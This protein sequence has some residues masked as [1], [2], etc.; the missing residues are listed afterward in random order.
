MAPLINSSFVTVEMNNSKLCIDFSSCDNDFTDDSC[1]NSLLL[2]IEFNNT[3]D[4]PD[5]TDRTISLTVS[6]TKH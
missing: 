6:L 5:L 1:F 3:L 4:E 2:G